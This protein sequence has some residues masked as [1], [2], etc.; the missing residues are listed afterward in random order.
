ME[1]LL[2]RIIAIEMMVV[3]YEHRRPKIFAADGIP[4]PG[5]ADVQGNDPGST[6]RIVRL[7][8]HFHRFRRAWRTERCHPEP[9]PDRQDAPCSAARPFQPQVTRRGVVSLSFGQA[10]MSFCR[11][12]CSTLPTIVTK[13]DIRE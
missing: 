1:M 6:G 13:P 11:C 7:A 9:S 8:P 5:I 4:H 12:S 10:N 3:K 2:K